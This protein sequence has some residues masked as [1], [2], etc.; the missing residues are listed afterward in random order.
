MHNRCLI[1]FYGLLMHGRLAPQARGPLVIKTGSLLQLLLGA[2]NRWRL[3]S[4]RVSE[5]DS[6]PPLPPSE[7]GPHWLAGSP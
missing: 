6:S 5:G 1:P 3:G 2:Q 7:D 4:Y